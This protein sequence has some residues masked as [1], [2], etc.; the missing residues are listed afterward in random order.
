M[1]SIMDI[2]DSTVPLLFGRSSHLVFKSGRESGVFDII[3][4]QLFDIIHDQ[5]R[6]SQPQFDNSKA[7]SRLN[8]SGSA[9]RW[10]VTLLF[11]N[12]TQENLCVGQWMYKPFFC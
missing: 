3:H 2:Q 1:K 9:Q 8:L 6:T 11:F 10:I 7:R 5:L 4:D 12:T